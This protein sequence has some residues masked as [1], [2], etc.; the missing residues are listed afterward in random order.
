M[1]EDAFIDAI[2]TAGIIVIAAMLVYVVIRLQRVITAAAEK[3][4]GALVTQHALEEG[5]SRIWQRI[6]LIEQQSKA[7]QPNDRA[8]LGEW[9]GRAWQR[10]EKIE[11]RLGATEKGEPPPAGTLPTDPPLGS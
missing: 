9:V 10:I 6:D 1:R 5:F 11:A 3:L 2:Q 4:Q 8:A 7:P